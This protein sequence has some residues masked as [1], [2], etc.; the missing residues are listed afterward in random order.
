MG[1][2]F[3]KALGGDSAGDA[4]YHRHH[5]DDAR[6]WAMDGVSV[7]R[8]YF[9]PWAER[10]K[11]FP[12]SAIEATLKEARYRDL[13]TTDEATALRGWLEY[14]QTRIKDLLARSM[15]WSA[16][17]TGEEEAWKTLPE[18]GTS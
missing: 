11:G 14:R 2:R 18:P 6:V 12:R 4:Q 13:I 8:K 17:G 5:R 1:D 9:Q 15:A 3:E 16:K 7:D 10:V